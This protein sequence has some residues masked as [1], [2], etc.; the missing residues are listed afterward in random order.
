[1]NKSIGK[2]CSEDSLAILGYDSLKSL[3]LSN[4]TLI[5]TYDLL[6]IPEN[7]LI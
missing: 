4:E 3:K 5:V 1:M 6:P 7:L 2:I